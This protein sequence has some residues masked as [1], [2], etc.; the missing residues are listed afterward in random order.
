MRSILAKVKDAVQKVQSNEQNSQ[1]PLLSD[2][3]NIL[4]L[5]PTN[6]PQV[7]NPFS[8]G[9]EYGQAAISAASIFGTK[10][11]RQLV[12]CDNTVDYYNVEDSEGEEEQKNSKTTVVNQGCELIFGGAITTP[13]QEGHPAPL[14]QQVAQK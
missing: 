13:I 9:A 12:D 8:S 2:L 3:K 11:P 14:S 10:A 5:E 1:S 4:S 6:K 7:P